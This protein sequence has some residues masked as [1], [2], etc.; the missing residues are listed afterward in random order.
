MFEKIKTFFTKISSFF[1]G[2]K[3][4]YNAL[5][6]NK[7]KLLHLG[8]VFILGIAVGSLGI[9]S[10]Y[11]RNYRDI[12][13]RLSEITNQYNQ[14][15]SDIEESRRDID[16]LRKLNKQ[17]EDSNRAI[18]KANDR[19]RSNNTELEKRIKE[20]GIIEERLGA[21]ISRLEER[22]RNNRQFIEAI[23]SGLSSIPTESGKIGEGFK[24]LRRFIEDN[25]RIL[26]KD[27]R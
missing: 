27:N 11:N 19:L 5:S 17:L 25:L 4:K 21:E 6:E 24:E 26:S 1:K 22:D 9:Y 8:I 3:E 7:K 15:I 2:T 16:E 14:L 12:K 23:K 10:I 20:F 18:G 13:G